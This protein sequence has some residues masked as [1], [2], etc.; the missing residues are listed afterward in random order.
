[1]LNNVFVFVREYCYEFMMVEYLLLVLFDNL[2]VCD[3]FKVCGVDIEV[4]KSELLVFVKDIMFFILD[5]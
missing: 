3:V 4:I 1:M 5:D 2:V